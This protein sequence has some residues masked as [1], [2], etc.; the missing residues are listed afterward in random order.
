MD[1]EEEEIPTCPLCLEELDS[2]DRAVKA[3]QCG[4]QVC[5]WCLHHIRE[6]LSARCPACRTPYEEQNFKFAEVNP[7]QAAKEAKER[8]TAKKERERREKLK[9][10]EKERA[11]AVAVS[12]LKAKS[13][14]K[15]A[16]IL[17][18]NLV[19]VIGLSLT[20][21]REE[22]IRRADMFGKFG[23]MMRIL[24]NRSHPFNADAPGGPS[25]SAYI[26]YYRDS[27]A[28]AAVRGMNNGVFDGRE[29]RCAIATTKYCD[30]FA[31]NAAAS[32][33]NAMFHCGNQFCMYYH[34]IAPADLVLTREEVLARQLGPPPPAHLFFPDS[35]RPNHA[36]LPFHRPGPPQ[37]IP[38]HPP[39]NTGVPLSTSSASQGRSMMTRPPASMPSPSTAPSIPFPQHGQPPIH[40][41][42]NMNVPLSMPATTQ[43][44][45]GASAAG[46][47][48]PPSS[49]RPRVPGN[50]TAGRKVGG[51]PQPFSPTRAPV[52]T[53]PGSPQ[54]GRSSSFLHRSPRKSE[55][56]SVPLSS[57]GA[58]SARGNGTRSATASAAPFF[59]PRS[60]RA[61]LPS[62]AG[63]AS[64]HSRNSSRSP[65]RRGPS[66]SLDES[67][68]STPRTPRRL[69]RDNAPPGFESAASSST[70]AAPS[71]PPGFDTPASPQSSSGNREGAVTKSGLTSGAHISAPPGFGP[72][73]V[74]SRGNG[75]EET[76]RN[77][78]AAAWSQEATTDEVFATQ[79]RR[80]RR[81]VGKPGQRA[82]LGPQSA[83]DSVPALAQLLAKRGKETGVS[84]ELQSKTGPLEISDASESRNGQYNLADAPLVSQ[85]PLGS[86]FG[87]SSQGGKVP[88]SDVDRRV[89]SPESSS[90][91]SAFSVPLGRTETSKLQESAAAARRNSSRFD[92]ARRSVP[93]SLSESTHPSTQ[94]MSIPSLE[95]GASK[96]TFGKVGGS[97]VPKSS[98]DEYAFAEMNP[99][100]VQGSSAV[101]STSH[102][103]KQARSRFG[104]AEQTSSPKSNHT[105]P[106]PEGLDSTANG[107]GL[108]SGFDGPFA[109]L[110]TAEKL[111]SLFHRAE[112]SGE[113]LPPMPTH[114]PQVDQLASADQ[115]LD[116]NTSHNRPV[117]A[118]PIPAAVPD[119]GEIR[120]NSPVSR[121]RPT[122][123]AP[124]GFR[125]A[126]PDIS[127]E[128][129]AVDNKTT[130]AGVATKV[131]SGGSTRNASE[132][133]SP[134]RTDDTVSSGTESIEE[135]RKR[136]RA[137]R[138]RDKKARQLREAA[139][140]K[141]LEVLPPSTVPVQS[142]DASTKLKDQQR[143]AAS[144]SGL[145]EM[146][147]T[148]PGQ[149]ISQATEPSKHLKQARLTDDPSRF[150]S[151][152]ELER[153]VEAARAREAQLQDRLQELQRRIRN[154]DNVRT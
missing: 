104:F 38:I 121:S 146:K 119:H 11:R 139:E 129:T 98:R 10:I 35:R 44:S 52:R 141:A 12:Q 74:S 80:P 122:Q 59:S 151:V 82:G 28:S 18:R 110:S 49:P 84:A 75:S 154:Y 40:V 37:P 20:L 24:V 7:E 70:S 42:P 95:R 9:E 3:C 147:N 17:Q 68:L 21:A 86:L 88:P 23:R 50:V 45:N 1:E 41:I 100:F 125:E 148:S 105:R 64:G 101:T 78:V 54:S 60:S 130:T 39:P 61:Q 5:L 87:K 135:D 124:P 150:M 91:T 34:S 76:D 113:R 62:N 112:W 13:N 140:R 131:A 26:Q 126:T 19:Y 120:K 137:Q 67:A 138:K 145:R 111:A 123:Y 149:I 107:E 22:V 132:A 58:S 53:P 92:F 65:P 71:R 46:Q 85:P 114:E 43:G 27:D 103:L 99:N 48:A 94:S 31:R 2:T 56:G 32:D 142:T 116:P 57:A 25:I 143:L 97:A 73:A 30:V 96:T 83:T 55:P 6:Q 8:A 89:K 4:Y 115:V 134:V 66:T 33:Q 136:S 109:N 127:P 90:Y 128:T 153:E 81:P 29:I 36:P 106:R 79:D 118:L 16:R 63:W 152:S 108:S 144:V 77:N 117:T 47:Q 102:A 15:H 69:P 14:F 133:L 72:T 51:P 93:E